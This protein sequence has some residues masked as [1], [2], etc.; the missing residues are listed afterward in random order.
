MTVDNDDDDSGGVSSSMTSPCG[1]AGP[2]GS[3][4]W[5]PHLHHTPQALE[6]PVWLWRLFS[7]R[8]QLQFALHLYINGCTNPQKV[9]HLLAEPFSAPLDR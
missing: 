6:T 9:L 7:Q 1:N 3:P 8:S 4:T 5:G 2:K